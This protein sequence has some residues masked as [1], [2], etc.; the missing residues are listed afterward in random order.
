MLVFLR[1]GGEVHRARTVCVHDE[2]FPIVVE[3]TFVGNFERQGFQAFAQ[4][5]F[6]VETPSPD[7]TEACEKQGK[8]ESARG[9]P[10]QAAHSRA[11]GGALFILVRH[12]SKLRGARRPLKL[13]A[14]CAIRLLSFCQ[15][16]VFCNHTLCEF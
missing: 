2:N 16:A 3:I 1:R 5:A 9:W 4:G 6:T 7:E 8:I 13:K 11:S 15:G 10:Q 14:G 12:D